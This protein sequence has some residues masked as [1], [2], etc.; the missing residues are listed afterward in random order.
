MQNPVLVTQ[1]QS[2]LILTTKNTKDK[3][4]DL[5]KMFYNFFVNFVPFVVNQI[6]D[7]ITL[8]FCDGF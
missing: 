6:Q 7:M 5:K 2:L 3:K 4:V 8:L 1:N